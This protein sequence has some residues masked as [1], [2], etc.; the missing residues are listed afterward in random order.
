M[1]L[2]SILSVSLSTL[3]LVSLSALASFSCSSDGDPEPQYSCSTKGPCPRDPT[4]TE[5]EANACEALSV[6]TTCG[7]AFRTYATCAFSAKVCT[8]AGL[9]DP[10][11]DSTSDAC[12]SA[13]AKYT[14]CLDNKVNEPAAAGA[15][16]SD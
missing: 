3:C 8:D 5:T 11:L 10:T 14:T 6:D 7:A 12:S 13:Y 16:G 1:N 4:P 15:G 9:S 2:R